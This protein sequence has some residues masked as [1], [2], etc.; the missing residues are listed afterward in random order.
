MKRIFLTVLLAVS[1][2]ACKTD[3][4]IATTVD[5]FALGTTYH[6]VALA[7]RKLELQARIDSVL[8]AANMSMSIY[9]DSSLVCRLNR[10][11]TDSMD[12]FI[13]DCV[14]T[15]YKVS[16]E[17]GGLYDITIKPL[18]E[19][20][21]FAAKE[22]TSNPN[23]DSLLQFVGYEKIKIENG[24]LIKE[25]PN[26]Q[27]DLNSIAKGYTVDLVAEFLAGLGIENYLVEIGGEIDC[28]GL[29]PSGKPWGV[30]ID[31]PIDGNF[32]PGENVQVVLEIT[33]IGLATSGN[34]RKFYTNEAGEKI[35]HTINPKTGVSEISNLLSATVLAK[36]CTLADAY[37]TMMMAIGLDESIRILESR[38]DIMG[39][40]IYTDKNG[41]FQ[42]YC[43]P[44]LE[45]QIRK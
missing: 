20:W 45:K 26:M 39:Y 4:Y 17:S 27:F 31:K 42:T 41:N 29:N 6:I 1:L 25:N 15:A 22:K 38:D 37:G 35:V 8:N 23:I 3:K 40:L 43:S 30:A 9:N 33:D 28:K 10:N 24:R 44:T 7:D 18:T 34:Y 12:R 14:E 21:G 5:G 13:T 2:T 32:T 19:A 11:E 36:N 16:V